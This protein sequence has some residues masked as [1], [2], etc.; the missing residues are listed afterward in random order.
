VY[1][2]VDDRDA[3]EAVIAG[4]PEVASVQREVAGLTVDVGGVSRAALVAALV[5]AGVGVQTVQ[6][7][8]Q[9]EDTFLGLVGEEHTR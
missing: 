4:L 1:L 2:E 9:L 5:N 8:R 6:A 3:A 7:R